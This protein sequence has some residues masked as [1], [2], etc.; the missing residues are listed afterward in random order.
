MSMGHSIDYTEYRCV[1]IENGVGSGGN[2]EPSPS[3][4]SEEEAKEWKKAQ[5]NP[6]D[7]YIFFRYTMH[8]EMT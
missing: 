4:R 5:P 8:W 2:V 3:F 7:W 6:D 1:D